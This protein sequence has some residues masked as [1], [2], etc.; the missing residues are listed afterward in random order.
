MEWE[1]IKYL[2]G[3]LQLFVT[4]WCVIMY[5]DVKKAK[6]D[7]AAHRL[8]IAEHYTTKSESTRAFDSLSETIKGLL[9]VMNSRFDKMDTKLDLKMD[10]GNGNQ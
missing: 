4:G 8:H 1:I 9:S 7:I 6:E 2:I 3:F 5:N 10:K